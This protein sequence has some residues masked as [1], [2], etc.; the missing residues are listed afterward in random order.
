LFLIGAN[1]YPRRVIRRAQV[2]KTCFVC[3]KSAPNNVIDIKT[4]KLV[5][6]KTWFTDNEGNYCC[7]IACC[8]K[9]AKILIIGNEVII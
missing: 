8:K 3:G 5:I 7:S 6:P 1:L 9:T 4:K 2:A